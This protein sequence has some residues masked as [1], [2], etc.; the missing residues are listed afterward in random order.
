MHMAAIGLLGASCYAR[1][2][3][4]LFTPAPKSASGTEFNLAPTAPAPPACTRS[5]D[6]LSESQATQRSYDVIDRISVTCDVD[7]PSD[8]KQRLVRRACEVGADA[9]V[10]SD[11]QR[12]PKPARGPMS[13]GMLV[14]WGDAGL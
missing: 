5:I 9:V 13:S 6:V 14:R 4:P 12:G 1:G 3:G 10:V 7:R 11:E 2:Y 8:C